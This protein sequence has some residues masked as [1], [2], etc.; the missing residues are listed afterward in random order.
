MVSSRGTE[1]GLEVIE[2]GRSFILFATKKGKR[3]LKQLSSLMIKKLKESFN[4]KGN[5]SITMK[6][7]ATSIS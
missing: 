1:M 3:S 6:M 7:I 2:K 4:D 5:K